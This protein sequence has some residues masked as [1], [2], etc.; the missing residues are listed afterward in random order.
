G[1]VRSMTVWCE[2]VAPRHSRRA[3]ERTA[4]KLDA[5]EDHRG[6]IGL[7]VDAAHRRAQTA[8]LE[9]EAELVAG[10]PELLY[11]GII[12]VSAPDRSGLDTASAQLVP[13]AAAAGLH[14]R[15]LH[16]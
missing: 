11:A 13:P 1:G 16:G 4:A 15:P 8:V 14:L 9:R 5:D 2:P 6:R 12:T 7:R 3:I 10:Y